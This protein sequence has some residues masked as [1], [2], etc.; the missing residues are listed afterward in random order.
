MKR[1]NLAFCRCGIPRNY[2]GILKFLGALFL[3][4]IIFEVVVQI[5]DFVEEDSHWLYNRHASNETEGYVEIVAD[6]DSIFSVRNNHSLETI[7]VPAPFSVVGFVP[8]CG[9][10]KPCADGEFSVH[11]STGREDRVKP[12]L[13]VDGKYVFGAEAGIAGRGMNVVVIDS[14]QSTVTR[15]ANF[16]TYG[17]SSKHL[18]T[19]LLTLKPGDI[20]IIFTHDESSK[21]LSRVSHV[22]LQDLGS[23]LIQNLM[24]RGSWFMISQKGITGFSPFED[25]HYTDPTSWAAEHNER[26]CVP[27]YLK[28][29]A[30]HPDPLPVENKPRQEYCSKYP[31]YPVFCDSDVIH[32]PLIPGPGIHSTGYLRVYNT[33]M[34]VLAGENPIT[35]PIT[36]ETI[37]RQPG[38]NPKMVTVFYPSEYPELS[39]LMG[40]FGFVGHPFKKTV[41]Y[42]DKIAAAFEVA[43]SSFEDIDI[44]IVVEEDVALGPDFMEYMGQL[45]HLLMVDSTLTAISAWNTNGFMGV[46]ENP[47]QVY[48]TEG[49]VGMAVA[50][51]ADLFHQKHCDKIS[52]SGKWL[53]DIF[54]QGESVFP[55]VSRVISTYSLKE[56]ESGSSVEE[57]LFGAER[58]TNIQTEIQLER[59]EQLEK[60]AYVEELN[61][62]F[63]GSYP[64][65]VDSST[66]GKCLDRK[67]SEEMSSYVFNVLV[68]LH[69]T[70]QV[71]AAYIQQSGPGD[72]LGFR[73][74]CQCI[75]LFHHPQLPPSG[76]YRGVLRFNSG[77]QHILLVGSSSPFYHYKP[78]YIRPL[79]LENVERHHSQQF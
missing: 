49:F 51:R 68:G 30:I 34:I 35:L 2:L 40:L 22:L 20:I 65:M 12:S 66:L 26:F 11:L 50:V 5:T 39:E 53:S 55:D 57:A 44:L 72:Y 8:N 18:E 3:C 56:S 60:Q 7:I 15:V 13:C 21:K 33:P 10:T 75:G 71:L 1:P 74:L 67:N 43:K 6:G 29:Q 24:Y 62:T 16:D 28:G 41:N 38:I 58:V 23:A 77:G 19:F 76:L 4:Y 42:C 25:I 54:Q 37:I 46:S 69:N 36:L 14:F 27:L 73:M 32:E 45:L 48:R 52:T 59:V 61:S 64:V 9:L 47:T 63:L 70:S 17:T 79:V 78:V 31:H